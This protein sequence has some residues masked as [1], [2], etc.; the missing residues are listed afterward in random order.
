MVI[1]TLFCSVSDAIIKMSLK[2]DVY[3][4]LFFHFIDYYSHVRKIYFKAHTDSSN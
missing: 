4:F 2:T 1:T 3:F